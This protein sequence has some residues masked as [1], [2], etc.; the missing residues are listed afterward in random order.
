MIRCDL[1]VHS[2]LSPCAEDE[3][4][5]FDLVGMAKLNGLDLIAL[6]DHNSVKNCRAAAWAAA[7]YGIGFLPGMEL[8]TSEEIHCICLFP[9]LEAAEDFGRYVD[10]ILPDIPNRPEFFGNQT[11]FDPD[12][13]PHTERRYLHPACN[14]SILDV[15]DACE[16]YGGVCW[17]AHVDRPSNGLL[18]VL[19]TWP[20]ELRVRA[21]EVRFITPPEVPDGL[22][23]IQASDAHRMEDMPEGGFLLRPEEPTFEALKAWLET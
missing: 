21:A 14:V 16:K 5:P 9:T 3:M 11:W 19:G 2:C 7:E 4:T 20:P 22:H 8:N 18:A 23:I 13:T 12:G 10:T 15:P 17:P 1:H 6:T